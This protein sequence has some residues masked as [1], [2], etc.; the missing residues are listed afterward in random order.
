MKKKSTL[1]F[2]G[3]C[4]MFFLLFSCGDQKKLSKDDLL[5]AHIPIPPKLDSAMRHSFDTVTY[6]ILKKLNPKNVKSF[7]VSK[8]NY[9]K[10]IDQIPVNADRVAFSFVQFNKDK[11]PNQYQELAQFDGELYMLYYYMDKSGKNIT[12]RAYAM[13]D[14]KQTIEI[15]EKD[16]EIMENDYINN[17]K[18]YIDKVVKGTQGNTLR[19]KMMKDELLAYKNRA[20]TKKNVKNFKITLAQWV[21]Y[22]SI[23]SKTESSILRK[24]LKLYTDESVGQ[25]TFITDCQNPEGGDVESLSGF[26]LNHFC[27]QDCP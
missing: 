21:N 22:E 23:L 11:F 1:Y 6:K 19:V 15:D 14:V 5:L 13:L 9:L 17:I 12:G 8:E 25:M 18:P 7:K 20:M 16:Y 24:K 26:D 2:L 4:M 27:P 10:M 3:Y